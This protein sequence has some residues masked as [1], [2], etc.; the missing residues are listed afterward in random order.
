MISLRT[1]LLAS[2]MS[3]QASIE[4]PDVA[5]EISSATESLKVLPV[6][7]LAALAVFSARFMRR[8]FPM[9]RRSA[10]RLSFAYSRALSSGKRPRGLK[11]RRRP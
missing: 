7:G 11:F 1:G 9:T 2:A 5:R 10:S 3:L 8:L 4:R 6:L